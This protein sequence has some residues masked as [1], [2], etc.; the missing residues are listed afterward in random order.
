MGRGCWL[1]PD[2][3]LALHVQLS[4]I[5]LTRME[6]DAGETVFVWHFVPRGVRYGTQVAVVAWHTSLLACSPY[7][8]SR[9]SLCSA[10]M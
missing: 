6:E 8:M 9:N 4:V 1:H 2:R 7:M 10:M 3:G 5:G